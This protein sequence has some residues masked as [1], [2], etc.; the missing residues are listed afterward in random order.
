MFSA[1]LMNADQGIIIQWCLL[2]VE[3]L[4]LDV[5]PPSRLGLRSTKAPLSSSSTALHP[6][7]LGAVAWTHTAGL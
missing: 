5:A 3:G 2:G 6:S 4:E 1:D 7:A